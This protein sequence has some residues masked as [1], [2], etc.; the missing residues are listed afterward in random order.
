MSISVML[1]QFKNTTPQAKH[2]TLYRSHVGSRTVGRSEVTEQNSKKIKTCYKFHSTQKAK[3]T[4]LTSLQANN[5]M[6]C[7]GGGGLNTKFYKTSK[8]F[9]ALEENAEFICL[10][11]WIH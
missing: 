4:N 9:W 2:G 1:L 5:A 3:C 7:I 6:C 10:C 8:H 11:L